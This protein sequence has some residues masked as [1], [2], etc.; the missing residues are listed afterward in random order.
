MN[1]F[2]TR[3]RTSRVTDQY[4]TELQGVLQLSSKAA[5][6]RIAI[7]LSLK[8]PYDPETDM[9]LVGHD[10]SG[11]EFQRSTL[12]GKYDALIKNLVIQ[13]YGQPL[14]EDKYFPDLLGIHLERGTRLLYNEVK[15]HGGKDK[16]YRYLFAE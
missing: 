8:D 15:Y 2:N 5:I 9:K 4:L 10:T 13:H 6:A 7:A 3:L 12:T 11:F 16:Y 14:E 1:V